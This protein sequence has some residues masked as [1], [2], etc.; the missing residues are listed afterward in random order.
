MPGGGVE[1]WREH[2]AWELADGGLFDS[3]QSNDLSA[4]SELSETEEQAA[5][6]IIQSILELNIDRLGSAYFKGVVYTNGAFIATDDVV[7]RGSVF[8]DGNPALDRL[9]LGE[10]SFGPGD[11][12]LFGHTTLTFVEE[13]FED[14][15]HNLAGNGTLDIK[16]WTTR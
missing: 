6:N 16:R 13:F 8:V 9:V 14:G 4:L 1:S 7:V 12:G 10:K 2:E 3:L 15:I 5:F 11:V